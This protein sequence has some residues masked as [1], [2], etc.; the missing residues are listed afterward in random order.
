MTFTLGVGNRTPQCHLLLIPAM[1]RVWG[2][3][4]DKTSRG[5]GVAEMIKSIVFHDQ[6]SNKANFFALCISKYHFRH[7]EKPES[8]LKGKTGS[9]SACFEIKGGGGEAGVQ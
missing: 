6:V 7:Q 3:I 9:A 1:W 5:M 2:Y 8:K 4:Q